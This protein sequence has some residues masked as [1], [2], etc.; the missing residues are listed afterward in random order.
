M[1]NYNLH[2]ILTAIDRKIPSCYTWMDRIENWFDNDDF[3]GGMR[4]YY[5][6]MLLTYNKDISPLLSQGVLIDEYSGLFTLNTDQ[7]K[8]KHT[9]NMANFVRRNHLYFKNK[10]IATVCRDYGIINT[11]I[12]MMGLD[13]TFSQL[14]FENFL[15]SALVMIGN[16]CPP[17]NVGIGEYDVLLVCNS[18]ENNDDARLTWNMMLDNRLDGKEVFFTFPTFRDLQNHILYDRIYQ[19]E[20][21]EQIYD[22]D[23]YENVDLGLQHKIYGI[24]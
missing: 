20:N 24:T 10:R 21:P 8:Y 3:D 23:A 2:P 4:D 9:F 11:Q 5:Y 13:L 6:N 17:Y 7:T 12:R 19:V 15:G 1:K 22:K 14:P 16:E 18:I